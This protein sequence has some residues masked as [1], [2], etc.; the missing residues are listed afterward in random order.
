MAATD[1]SYSAFSIISTSG[2]DDFLV[3]AAGLS[4]L[5]TSALTEI[6]L[7]AGEVFATTSAPTEILLGDKEEEEVVA[8]LLSLSP[9]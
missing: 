4:N 3:A 6:L 5:A 9:P 8:I 7:A 2:I 1:S